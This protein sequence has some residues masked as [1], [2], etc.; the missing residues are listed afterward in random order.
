MKKKNG[1]R[2]STNCLNVM[3]TL[4]IFAGPII[5]FM[6]ASGMGLI[7][8]LVAG[9]F[10]AIGYWFAAGLAEDLQLAREYLDELMGDSTLDTIRQEIKLTR[11][12]VKTEMKATRDAIAELKAEQANEN[13]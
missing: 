7:V 2:T 11:E 4:A 5:G 10:A 13:K 6:V 9:I 8:G 1:L 3:A 12:A